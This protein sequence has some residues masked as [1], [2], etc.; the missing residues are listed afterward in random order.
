MLFSYDPFTGDS[1]Y[2]SASPIFVH[3]RSSC[4]SDD[5]HHKAGTVPLQQRVRPLSIRGFNKQHMMVKT[6][7]TEGVGVLEACM[8]MLADAD[9][10]YLHLHNARPGC[11][12]VKVERE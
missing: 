2:R 10:E 11:F 12:A 6:E 9:V 8:E 4:E 1:P 3:A 7:L 5:R